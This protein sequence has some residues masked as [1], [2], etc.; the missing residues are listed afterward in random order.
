[1]QKSDDQT[2]F[3]SHGRVNRVARIEI[4]ED[5]ISGIRSAAPNQVARFEIAHDYRNALISK[6]GLD[7]LAEKQADVSKPDVAG[8]VP[9]C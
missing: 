8:R 6:V 4:T 7:S 3:A 5:R 9:I 2:C 1:M